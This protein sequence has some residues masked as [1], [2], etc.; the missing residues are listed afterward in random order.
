MVKRALSLFLCSALVL[1]LAACGGK[2]AADPQ[3]GAGSTGKSEPA[4]EPPAAPDPAPEQ[5]GGAFTYT[6]ANG[7]L[8]ISGKGVLDQDA[9]FACG[10]GAVLDA[11]GDGEGIQLVLEDGVTEI[12]DG[13]FTNWHHMT[14][15]TIPEGVTKIGGGAFY[16]CDALTDVA[17]PEGVTEIGAEAFMSCE[18]L[19]GVTI[20]AS[21]TAIGYGAFS[22]CRSLTSV[23]IPE[24][25]TEIG[26]Y[27]FSNCGLTSVTIPNP[28]A[29]VAEN[30]FDEGVTVNP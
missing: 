21:V 5:S 3:A 18:D 16:Q 12:G 24:G 25:V 11:V 4:G 9:L 6:Y 27:A 26:E 14:D 22:G 23:T 20:P 19:T 7:V 30:A 17:I 8:T 13:A 1:S 2:I 29:K 15:V 10:A 28:D